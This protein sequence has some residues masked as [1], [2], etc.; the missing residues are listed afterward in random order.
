MLAFVLEVSITVLQ[1][2][3]AERLYSAIEG[4]TATIT[5]KVRRFKGP[6]LINTI[7]TLVVPMATGIVRR[8]F[9]Y[10]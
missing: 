9:K 10:P 5:R 7:L 1:R 6:F 4:P 8:R 3:Q 2:S